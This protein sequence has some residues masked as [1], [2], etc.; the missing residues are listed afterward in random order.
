MVTRGHKTVGVQWFAGHLF[1]H[2]LFS[3]WIATNSANPT[4]SYR[5][6]LAFSLTRPAK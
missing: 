1:P 2:Q 3:R 6:P 5:H 4:V